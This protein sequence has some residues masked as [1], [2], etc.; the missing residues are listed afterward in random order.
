MQCYYDSEPLVIEIHVHRFS[1]VADEIQLVR[2]RISVL[3]L[4][5][6]YQLITLALSSDELS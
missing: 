1:L 4:S 3:S 2:I 5:S 6:L